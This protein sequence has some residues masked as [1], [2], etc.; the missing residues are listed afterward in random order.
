MALQ[1]ATA[2]S[3]GQPLGVITEQEFLTLLKKLFVLIGLSEQLRKKI[4]RDVKRHRGGMDAMF[5]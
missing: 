1:L 3:K 5:F 2:R 4:G